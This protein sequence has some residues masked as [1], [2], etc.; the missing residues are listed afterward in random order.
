APAGLCANQ[1]EVEVTGVGDRRG[2]RGVFGDA[3]ADDVEDLTFVTG[4]QAVDERPR[5]RPQVLEASDAPQHLVHS[6]LD[7]L[8]GGLLGRDLASVANALV[9]AGPEMAD[10]PILL[11]QPVYAGLL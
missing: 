2:Q 9:L 10:A 4:N 11:A 8:H 6:D 7:R 5:A 3:T 1:G